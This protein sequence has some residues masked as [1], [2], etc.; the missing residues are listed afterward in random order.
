ML[1]FEASVL[2]TGRH[3]VTSLMRLSNDKA[4]TGK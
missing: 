3:A 2:G 4:L 1:Q